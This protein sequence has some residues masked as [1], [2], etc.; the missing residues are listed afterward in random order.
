MAGSTPPG[1]AL[2]IKMIVVYA[3]IIIATGILNVFDYILT[4]E[5]ISKYGLA[6]E[7]NPLARKLFEKFGPKGV[8]LFKT[9]LTLFYCVVMA[10]GGI[11][12]F[13]PVIMGASIILLCIYTGVVFTSRTMLKILE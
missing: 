6:T 12:S 13:G 2:E 5:F 3:L 9:A 7:A 4:C 1:D 8:G 10:I 11:Y